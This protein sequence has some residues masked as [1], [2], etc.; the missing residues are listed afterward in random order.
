ML[1]RQLTQMVIKLAKVFDINIDICKTYLLL[2]TSYVLVAGVAQL[3][4]HTAPPPPCTGLLASCVGLPAPSSTVPPHKARHSQR[5]V[6]SSSGEIPLPMHL[7][8]VCSGQL[9][10]LFCYVN[11]VAPP[12][13]FWPKDWRDLI[14]L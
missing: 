12:V 11:S 10:L 2:E 6:W 13:K 14:I 1:A 4:F 9:L 7:A 5:Q 8:R 3:L